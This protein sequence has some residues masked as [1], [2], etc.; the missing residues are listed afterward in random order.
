MAYNTITL[1]GLPAREERAAEAAITPGF[2]IELTSSDTV[3]A[4]STAGGSAATL[5]ALEDENQGN[6]IGDAYSA[7]DIVL[8][9]VFAPGME[10]YALLA[11]GEDIAI[12]DLL[13]SNGDGYLREVD[14]DASAGTIGVQ[15][16][17]GVALEALDMSGSSG[18]DP[19]SQRLRILVI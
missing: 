1:K 11:D 7:D 4:H 12:G 14:A 2:L 8:F 16:I 15:S 18:E 5:F 6:E 17:V 3:Q 19:S 13:E 9:G 10:V